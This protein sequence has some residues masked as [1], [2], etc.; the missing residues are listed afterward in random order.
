LFFL[1]YDPERV[2][3]VR[4]SIR[5]GEAPS[6]NPFVISTERSGEISVRML[7]PENAFQIENPRLKR[8]TWVTRL[9]WGCNLYRAS[10]RDRLSLRDY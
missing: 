1:S 2:P 4:T 8:Q 6:K 5:A 3:H 10:G 9:I 7:Y